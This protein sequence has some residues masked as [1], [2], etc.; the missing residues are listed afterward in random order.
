MTKDQAFDDRYAQSSRLL[1]AHERLLYLYS[2]RHHRH[3]CLVGEFEGH[4]NEMNLQEALQQ[5]RQRYA[6]LQ[7]AVEDGDEGPRFIEHIRPLPVQLITSEGRPDWQPIVEAELA[8]PFH[9]WM[10]PLMRTSVLRGSTDSMRWVIVLTFHHSIADGLSGVA[11]LHGLARALNGEELPAASER[12]PVEDLVRQVLG[13]RVPADADQTSP[14]IPDLE[15]IEAIA[16]RPLWRPFE[17]DRP[18]VGAI[19]LPANVTSALVGKARKEGSTVH[20]AICAAVAIANAAQHPSGSYAIMSPINMRPALRIEPDEMGLFITAAT[21]RVPIAARL[22]LWD[23]ARSFAEELKPMRSA[24]H[25]F[26]SIAGVDAILPR[27]ATVDLA[28]GLVGS[29]AYDAVVSNLGVVDANLPVG[30]TRL[31]AIWGPLVLGRIRN[32][33]MI[34]S[35]TIGG[36]LRLTEA[37]PSHMPDSLQQI[38]TT[39][40][41]A[42]SS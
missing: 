29:L 19:A 2:K 17:A 21:I 40:A 13:A 23:L 31:S 22:P 34:G 20:G 4:L 3:F 27:N 18:K 15:T 30:A 10:G 33:R 41:D 37:R 26:R 25:L 5:L 7:L 35:A 14:G 32:E 1:G 6:R 11:F 39:L 24:Q 42:C 16:R 12:K 28:C 8:K 38:V 9:P 36:Y